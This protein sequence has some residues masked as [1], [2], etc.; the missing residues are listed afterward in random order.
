MAQ[1]LVSLQF[2]TYSKSIFLSQS[3]ARPLNEVWN[4]SER[5]TVAHLE[6]ALSL[7]DGQQRLPPEPRVRAGNGS[8]PEHV[9]LPVRKGRHHAEGERLVGRVDVAPHADGAGGRGRA[10]RR[11]PGHGRQVRTYNN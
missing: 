4:A 3:P 8:Q 6:S 10:Q 9:F 5:K 7:A 1:F 2:N 11:R